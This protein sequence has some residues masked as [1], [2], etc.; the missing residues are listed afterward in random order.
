MRN[1]IA[2]IHLVAKQFFFLFRRLV[3]SWTFLQHHLSFSPAYPASPLKNIR[4]NQ[5]PREKNAIGRA[6]CMHKEIIKRKQRERM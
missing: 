1:C 6:N 3:D 5:L 4:N 2:S